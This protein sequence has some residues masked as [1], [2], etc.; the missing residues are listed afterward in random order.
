MAEDDLFAIPDRAH[1]RRTDPETSHA[2]AKVVDPHLQ[3]IRDRVAFFARQ[4]GEIGFIDEEL[5][6]KFG[7]EASSSYRTRRNELTVAGEIVDSGRKKKN[8]SGRDC[9]VWVHRNFLSAP[10]KMPP[11]SSIDTKVAM[12]FRNMEAGAR[13]MRNEGRIGFAEQIEE[14]LKVLKPLAR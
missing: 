10:P 6:A 12:A 1:A 14:A 5:S 7:A 8:G 11:M 2:A 3:Q 9:I 4:C 13:Q